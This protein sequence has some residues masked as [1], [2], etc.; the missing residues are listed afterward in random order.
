MSR[1]LDP[2]HMWVLRPLL[3]PIRCRRCMRRFY[4]FRL[5]WMVTE[6]ETEAE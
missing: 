1:S 2:W 6:A 5:L 4:R 3:V